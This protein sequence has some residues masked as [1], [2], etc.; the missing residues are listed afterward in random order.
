MKLSLL[1]AHML[2]FSF[3]HAHTHEQTIF[4]LP[5]RIRSDESMTNTI[6]LHVLKWCSHKF[7]YLPCPE[8]SKAVNETP[9]SIIKQKRLSKL[10]KQKS[11]A[12]WDMAFFV[13]K[14][15]SR[16]ECLHF[17]K[18]ISTYSRNVPHWIQSWAPRWTCDRLC[19]W[20]NSQLSTCR[21]C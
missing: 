8:K 6:P 13:I 11:H 4:F 15:C 1:I 14:F 12:I 20:R 10:N 9:W 18:L 2:R 3:S 21:C 19:F 16:L 5:S 7:L 17:T